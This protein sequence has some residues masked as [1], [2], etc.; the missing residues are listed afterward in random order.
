MEPFDIGLDGEEIKASPDFDNLPAE[1]PKKKICQQK[2]TA[3]S[4]LSA[5]LESLQQDV[6]RLTSSSDSSRRH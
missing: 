3:E 4:S 6:V 2:S 1:P 5:L